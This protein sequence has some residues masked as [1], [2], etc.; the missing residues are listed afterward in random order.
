M[1]LQYYLL[2][3]PDLKKYDMTTIKKK[4]YED[5]QTNNRITTIESFF[6]NIMILI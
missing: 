2:F 3:N 4:F 5:I 1:S 6:K